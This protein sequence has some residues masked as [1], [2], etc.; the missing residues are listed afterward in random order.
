MEIKGLFFKEGLRVRIV[1]LLLL[2][3]FLNVKIN[4]IPPYSLQPFQFSG[5]FIMAL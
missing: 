2:N 5:L 3:L 4:K 1:P